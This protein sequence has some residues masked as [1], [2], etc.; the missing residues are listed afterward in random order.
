[1]NFSYSLAPEYPF[2]TQINECYEV[3][4]YILNNAKE[5]GGDSKRIAL[6]GDSVGK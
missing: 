1:M 3:I 2:P 4:M 5:L 6:A